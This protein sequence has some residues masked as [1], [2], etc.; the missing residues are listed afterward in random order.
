MGG[1]DPATEAWC[2]QFV[3]SALRNAGIKGSGSAVA[4][5]FQ[6][7]GNRV[8]PDDVKAGGGHVGM[9]TGATRVGP[10]GKQQFEMEAGNDANMVRRT[11]HNVDDPRVHF[12]RAPSDGGEKKVAEKPFDPETMV[13]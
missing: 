1:F 13:P 11:W 4:N 12:R 7:W 2:A 3:N 10:N 8:S 6:R 9:A 5:S